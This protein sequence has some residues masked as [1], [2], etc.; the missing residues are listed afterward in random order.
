MDPNVPNQ[1][2]PNFVPPG[3]TTLGE[4]PSVPPISLP[5]SQILPASPMP[6]APKKVSGILITGL[7]LL[8]ISVL[9]LVVYYFYQTNQLRV[10]VST[11]T[12]NVTVAPTPTATTNP[13]ADW[14]TYTNTKYNFSLKYPLEYKY[15]EKSYSKAANG[16]YSYTQI[17]L[18][19]IDD[20]NPEPIGRPSIMLTIIDSISHAN[21]SVYNNSTSSG[22]I[23]ANNIQAD[24]RQSATGEEVVVFTKNNST[25]EFTL[26]NSSEDSTLKS[27]LDQIL[28][29][30]QFTEASPSASATP[31]A[32]PTATSI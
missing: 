18:A 16:I 22:S 15:E 10:N 2:V 4:Q 31:S 11:P 30:F 21:D 14:K 6:P 29:T 26:S 28:S 9:A 20:F 19:N 17:T 32:L 25:F 8:F 23:S 27:N 5:T 1:P 12:P 7:I 3:G 24:V 13:T